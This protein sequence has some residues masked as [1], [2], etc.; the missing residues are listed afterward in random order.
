[1]GPFRGYAEEGGVGIR[2]YVDKILVL[3]QWLEP[4]D[5][6]ARFPYL[7]WTLDTSAF[8]NGEHLLRL[9]MCDHNDHPGVASLKAK[10]QN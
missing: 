5:V 4:D 3:D 8:P 1:V 10:F 7:T 6:K 2:G 9:S